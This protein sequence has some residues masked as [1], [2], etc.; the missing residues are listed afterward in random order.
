[1]Y[2]LAYGV[3][4]AGVIEINTLTMPDHVKDRQNK[5]LIHES[6][7]MATFQLE[8][9]IVISLGH[10]VAPDKLRCPTREVLDR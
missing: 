6:I 9:Q 7:R 2:Q 3:C 1:L 4:R 5:P 8:I 10:S